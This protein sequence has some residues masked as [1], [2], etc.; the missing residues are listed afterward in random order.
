VVLVGEREICPFIFC[1]DILR[2]NTARK[3]PVR[4]ADPFPGERD[5]PLFS[6]VWHD[7]DSREIQ[8]PHG[9]SFAALLPEEIVVIHGTHI[10]HEKTG[11]L[12]VASDSIFLMASTNDSVTPSPK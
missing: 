4:I 9:K 10:H 5:V 3:T 7:G 11:P 1:V 6:N 2:C 8:K 12:S